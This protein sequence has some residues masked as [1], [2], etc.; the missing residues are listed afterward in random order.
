MPLGKRFILAAACGITMKCKMIQ[1]FTV[2]IEF[3][4]NKKPLEESLVVLV[5]LQWIQ[6]WWIFA[7]AFFWKDMLNHLDSN[8]KGR[9][10][11]SSSLLGTLTKDN[12]IY[13]F[14]NCGWQF[15]FVQNYLCFLCED[16][17][18][19]WSEKRR[20]FPKMV[21]PSFLFSPPSLPE[22]EKMIFILLIVKIVGF[23]GADLI[24]S[25]LVTESTD[26]IEKPFRSLK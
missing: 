20:C 9:C 23:D 26:H 15:Y 11:S 12:S 13:L 24:I 3:F 5:S 10:V 8:R 19:Y 21:D 14:W 16:D 25:L 18:L 22:R 7:V 2:A 17:W 4:S 6:V 1:Q